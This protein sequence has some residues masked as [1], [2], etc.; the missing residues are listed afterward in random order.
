MEI[1]ES[2]ARCYSI[3]PFAVLKEDAE[4]VIDVLNY[5][6]EKNEDAPKKPVRQTAKDGTVRIRV[7]EKTATGGW[8]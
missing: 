2:V 4:D 5:L 8:Y 3:T 1:T 6:V 7:D